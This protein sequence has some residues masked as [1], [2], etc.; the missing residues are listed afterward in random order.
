MRSLFLA[1]TAL[2]TFAAASAFAADLEARS[3]IDSVAVHPDAAVVTRTFEVDLPDGASNVSLRGLPYALDPASL[4]VSGAGSA[5]ISIGAVESRTAPADTKT[6]TANDAK[7]KQL[8]SD[9]AGWQVTLDAL[10][11]KQ[12]MIQRFAQASPEKL[13][14]DKPLDIG[15]WNNAFDTVGNAL[16]KIGDELRSARARAQEIDDDIKAQEAARPRPSAKPPLRDIAIALNAAGATKAKFSVSY[17]V[18]GASWRPAYEAKLDT[19]GKDRKPALDLVRRAQVA[20][21]T[22]EDWSDVALTL[23]TTRALRGSQAPDV[24]PQRLAFWEPPVPM[25]AGSLARS[26]P[27]PAMKAQDSAR[28][29]AAPASAPPV[30]AAEQYAS[31]DSDAWQASFIVPGRLNVPADGAT[32]SFALASKRYDP[33]LAVRT[34]PSID[35]TAYLEAR[36]VNDEDAPLLAG[37]ITV[38]RDGAYVGQGQLAFVAAGDG[39]DLGFGADDRVKVTRVPVKKKEN[40]PTWYNQTKIDTREFKTS[41]KNLHDFPIRTTI[42]DRIPFSENTAITVELLPQTTPPTEKQVGDKRGVMSWTY[43]LAA[44]EQ[45]DVRLAWRM[46]WPA[47]RDVVTQPAPV[48]R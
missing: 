29:E 6:D 8:R 15:Q 39:F 25:A 7:L 34:A 42:V 10:S 33:Q 23:S 31:L 43:D 45:K 16:A 19:G 9:R 32:K 44:G 47:D 1:S 12:A 13:G 24:Q 28:N 17:R 35:P 40:E 41:V 48:A 37:P 4:R 18:S 22:G 30:Q 14:E 2:S 3:R 38:L 46:K 26:A 20:Q 5:A 36:L 27:A 21:N 11:A